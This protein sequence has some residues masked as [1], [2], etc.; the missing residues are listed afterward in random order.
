MKTTV[1]VAVAGMVVTMG[2]VASAEAKTATH[3]T[4]S[5]AYTHR[6]HK[7]ARFDPN[8]PKCVE[9]EALDPGGAYKAYP[10]WARAA[11]APK[12]GGPSWQ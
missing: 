12:G 8:D 10:C 5:A 3:T 1:L 7:T 2:T 4:K 6:S 9:A 11:L